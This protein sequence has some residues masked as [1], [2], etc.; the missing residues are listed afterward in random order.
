[1][2]HDVEMGVTAELG[3]TRMLLR[4]ILDARPGL[5]HR[6][7]PGRRRPGRRDGQ[8]HAHRPGEVVVIDEE[9]G[10][11]IT[12]IIGYERPRRPATRPLGR[13]R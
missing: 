9:F 11:R 2:L 5:G 6:A 10:I 3:R 13:R 7:R 4:D 12:E 8:R 1:M